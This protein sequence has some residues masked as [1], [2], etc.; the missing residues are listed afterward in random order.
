MDDIIEITP[1]MKE[2]PWGNNYFIPNLMNEVESETPIG[3]LW[4]GAH[5]NSP[6][7]VPSDSQ[8]P[9][10]DFLRDHPSFIQP[11]SEFPFLFKVLAIEKPLSIQCHPLTEQALAGYAGEADK[12]LTLPSELW[13]Y[14]DSNQKA[15]MLYALTRTTAMCGFRPYQELRESFQTLIPSSW[16]TYF[17][18]CDTSDNPIAAFFHLLYTLAPQ[19]LTSCIQE[20]SYSLHNLNMEI[21]GFLSAGQIALDCLRDYPDDPGV[22]SPFFLNVVTLEPGEAIYLRPGVVHAYVHGN[23]MELMN[24]SDNILRAGLTHKHMDVAELER[25]MTA[26]AQSVEKLQSFTDAAGCH[27]ITESQDFAMTILQDGMFTAPGATVEI[28]LC[29]EGSATINAGQSRCVLQKG[30]CY[31]IGRTIQKYTI[32]VFGTVISA[33]LVPGT[34]PKSEGAGSR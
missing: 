16:E 3:E 34:K 11:F 19:D 13:N 29:L 2:F 24:N 5:P 18:S 7:T 26:E 6:S 23:G 33:R 15:E 20:Y 30:S 28:L 4:M 9:L 31:L 21:D 10:Y 17:A 22:F 32:E 1:R 25:I 27:L 12:R 8:R 14:Q